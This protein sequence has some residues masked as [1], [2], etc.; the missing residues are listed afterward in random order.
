M[1]WF[2]RQLLFFLENNIPENCDCLHRVLFLMNIRVVRHVEVQGWAS[3]SQ[4]SDL[5]PHHTR[6]TTIPLSQLFDLLIYVYPLSY[7]LEN[8]SFFCILYRKNLLFRNE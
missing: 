2:I 6:A 7:E 4:N 3:P 1:F 5:K 8:I